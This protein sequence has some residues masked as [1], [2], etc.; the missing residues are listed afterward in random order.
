MKAADGRLH[1]GW[2]C[3]GQQPSREHIRYA[4]AASMKRRLKRADMEQAVWHLVQRLWVPLQAAAAEAKARLACSASP[5]AGDMCVTS[6]SCQ[7]TSS[8]DLSPSSMAGDALDQQQPSPAAPSDKYTPKPRQLTAALLV[9]GATRM[10]LVRRYL[11]A[12]SGL[13]PRCGLH[14]C[15]AKRRAAS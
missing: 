3:K 15:A 7:S 6:G 4:G 11:K 1:A 13:P 8:M 2:D 14:G 10:P 5:A 9:G 12:V